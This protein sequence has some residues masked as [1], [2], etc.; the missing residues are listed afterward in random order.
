MVTGV[1]H[2]SEGVSSKVAGGSGASSDGS[3]RRSHLVPE[4]FG[5]RAY[6][7]A[8]YQCLCYHCIVTDPIDFVKQLDT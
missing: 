8:G 4:G 6:V 7:N 5:C 2:A 3:T 1:D